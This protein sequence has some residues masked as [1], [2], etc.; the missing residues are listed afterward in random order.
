MAAID[1]FKTLKPSQESS[2]YF[3]G[4][5]ITANNTN[6]LGYTT[7]AIYVGSAGNMKVKLAGIFQAN[8]ANTSASRN[9]SNNVVTLTS[10]KAGEIYPIR[11]TRVMF[12]NTTARNLVGLL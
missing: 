7:R 11:A 8:T 2:V 10:L 4:F 3:G 9:I 6:D 12:S 5:A 1:R